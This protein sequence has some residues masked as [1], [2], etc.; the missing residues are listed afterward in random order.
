MFSSLIEK[1]EKVND[2]RK[3]RGKRHSL[4]KILLII[5]L[6]LMTGYLGYRGLESFIQTYRQELLN[7]L[8]SLKPKTQKLPSYS[9]LR[10][11][12]MGINYQDLIAIF[13]E[14]AYWN[15]SK[16]DE[17]DWLAIDGKSIRST[18]VNCQDS[19][20]NF[21]IVVS[22]FSQTTSEV[23]RL[24]VFESKK[25]SEVHQV[26]EM[27][28]DCA[29]EG[30]VFTGDSLHCN[31]P[32]A[33]TILETHNHYLLGIKK[34][35]IKLYKRV[36]KLA[37]VEK[38]NSIC[39]S[40][41]RSHGREIN[42]QTQVFNN[43]QNPI[44]KWQHLQNFIQVKRS[45]Y[46]GSKTYEE[47]AYYGSSL[48]QKA[49]VFASAIQGHWRIENKLHWVKDVIFQEDSSPITHFQAATNFSTLKTIGMNVF[50]QL[51]FDSM[52]A[53]KRWLANPKNY[54]FLLSLEFG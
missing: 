36:E 33:S 24:G 20:Q 54:I 13:N 44:K 34:N 1:L 52:T 31:L 23:V 11:V 41:D 39:V 51:G 28:R 9:T 19:Q 22:M 25:G 46:R 2:F 47:I 12:M 16:R 38:S 30:K 49:E 14:W 7:I 8:N 50:K 21:I 6:G 35:Q 37:K 40:K 48:C 17:L 5:I 18:I 32:L 43:F 26:Q 53:G 27:V 3:S 29:L 10:R 15:Y 45:G 42:R 4:W